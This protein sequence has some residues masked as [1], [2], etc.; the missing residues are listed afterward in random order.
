MQPAAHLG[1]GMASLS[2]S[3]AWPIYM[4][5]HLQILQVQNCA[6]NNFQVPFLNPSGNLEWVFAV[7]VLAPSF[8]FLWH[9]D[10]H[11]MGQL[12]E[13]PKKQSTDQENPIV[14]QQPI[15]V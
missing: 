1:L 13:M 12:H 5:R 4:P 8:Y 3:A 6:L 11:E 14:L 9:A 10:E 15:Q 7:P 2:S